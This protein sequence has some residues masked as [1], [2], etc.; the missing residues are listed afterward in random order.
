MGLM[1]GQWVAQSTAR[2]RR[3]DVREG[4]GRKLPWHRSRLV[5]L[6][7]LARYG[8]SHKLLAGL[9]ERGDGDVGELV[10]GGFFLIENG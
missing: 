5:H 9:V 8:H 4:G 3:T 10:V 7:R 2:H 1:E 6:R